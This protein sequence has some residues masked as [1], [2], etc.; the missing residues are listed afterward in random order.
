MKVCAGIV[1]YNPELNRLKNNIDAVLP[2]VDLIILVDNASAEIDSLKEIYS[3]NRFIWICNEKNIG[4]AGALNQ[5]VNYAHQN[6]YEWILTLDQDSVCGDD[7]VEKLLDTAKSSNNAGMICPRVIERGV[8]NSLKDGVE[9]IVDLQIEEVPLCITSG[10]LTNVRAVLDTG[11]FDERLFIDHVDHDM[12]IRL[13]YR[14][15]RILQVNGA[16]LNQEYGLEVVHRKLF[17]KTYEYHNYTPFRVYYQARNML[18]MVR[19]YGTDFKPRPFLHYFRPIVVFT[20]KFL[21]EPNKFRRLSAFARGY[22]AGLFMK[23]N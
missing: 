16:V 12:C 14:G 10:C 20:I 22:T 21:F 3:G 8:D 2:Q 6:N 4:V 7:L 23:I 1:L 15:Y 19:K 11:G 17:F 9:N 5:L 13:R 18:F